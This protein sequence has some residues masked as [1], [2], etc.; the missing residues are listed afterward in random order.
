MRRVQC[1]SFM[2]FYFEA[3]NPFGDSGQLIVLSGDVGFVETDSWK[4]NKVKNVHGIFGALL[5]T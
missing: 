4:V 5:K 2:Y 1:T 3:F